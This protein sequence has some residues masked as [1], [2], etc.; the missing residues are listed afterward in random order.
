MKFPN[1]KTHYFI[2]ISH[3][4]RPA[5]AL[6]SADHLTYPGSREA[7]HYQTRLRHPLL[8]SRDIQTST[9]SSAWLSLGPYLSS[10]TEPRSLLKGAQ[11]P[12][13]GRREIQGFCLKD[14]VCRQLP[15]RLDSRE[16]GGPG[17]GGRELATYV[18][19]SAK[20]RCLL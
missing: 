19:Q 16:P 7:T 1:L 17:G 20:V 8:I 2:I 15:G 18:A 3:R 6:L 12:P 9:C 5:A 13:E 4:P 11:E 10:D 14:T